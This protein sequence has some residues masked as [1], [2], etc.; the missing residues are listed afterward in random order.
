VKL[1]DVLLKKR[2]IQYFIRSIFGFFPIT[3]G[4]LLNL[5]SLSTD[6]CLSKQLSEQ[7]ICWVFYMRDRFSNSTPLK[8]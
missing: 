1:F 4:L 6:D 8:S 2:L 7:Y 3:A 5:Q